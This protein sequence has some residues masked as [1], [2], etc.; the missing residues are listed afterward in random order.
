M[1]KLD[2]HNK[3]TLAH[4]NLNS[5]ELAVKSFNQTISQQMN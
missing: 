5:Y 1:K 3:T 4:K 2:D